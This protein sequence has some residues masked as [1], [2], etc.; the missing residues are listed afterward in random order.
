MKAW[1]MT[2][3]ASGKEPKDHKPIE[4]EQAT[5]LHSSMVLPLAQ[6]GTCSMSSVTSLA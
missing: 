5:L 3:Q 1:Q 6:N 4:E 2:L